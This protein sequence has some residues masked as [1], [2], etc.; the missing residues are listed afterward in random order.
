MSTEKDKQKKSVL[1]TGASSGMGYSVAHGLQDR[2][3]QVIATVRKDVD[4]E[5][6]QSEGLDVVMLDLASTSSIKDCVRQTLERTNGQLYGL[7]NNAA[8]GQ[9]GAVEDLSRN[10]LREQFEVNLFGTQ[11][12]TN[13]IIPIMRDQKE[14]RIIQNSSMLG[15]VALSHRGAYNA[16]KFALE[17]LSHTMRLEL[18]DSGVF[19]SLIEPGPVESQFRSNALLAFRRNI[20]MENSVHQVKY[21]LIL[22]RLEKEGPIVPFT[23]PAESILKKVIH[24][25]ESSRPKNHYFLTF[26]THLF[27]FLKRVLPDRMLQA[28]LAKI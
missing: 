1:I 24:A 6:L 2:G 5:R 12:L 13:L 7:F 9:P 21:K 11:E 26:P 10:T 18:K 22:E 3:Y 19:V 27:A 28:I 15:L 4:R 25:L 17:G 8:Y 16:S 23:L 14:G 20:D